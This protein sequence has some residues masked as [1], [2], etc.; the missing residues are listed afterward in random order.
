M[1]FAAFP[2]RIRWTTPPYTAVAR[3]LGKYL[4]ERDAKPRVLIGMGY[5]RVGTH[6]AAQLATLSRRRRLRF[7]G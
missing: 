5:A 3:A 1:A 2:A 6:I 7:R 4:L